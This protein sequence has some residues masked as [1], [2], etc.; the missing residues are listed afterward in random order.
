[1]PQPQVLFRCF[2][3]GSSGN[4]YYLGTQERGVLID[5]GISARGIQKNLREMGLDFQNIMGVLVTHDHADHIRA[6]GTL[7]ERV[8]L[9][10][11]TTKQIHD[12]ID[13]NWGVH[14]KLRTSRRYIEKGVPFQLFDMDI[15]TFGISHDSTD[16]LGYVI[17][18]FG[19]RFMIATDCGEPNHNMEAFIQTANHIVIE[20]N[21]DEQLLLNGPYPTYLK[22]RI[23]SPRGHQS[24]DTCGELLVRNY[25]D[26][27]RN[28]FLCH[29]SKENNDPQLALETIA[30]R[31]DNAG[32]VPG[33]DVFV[34][35]LDRLTPSPV[36]VLDDDIIN[37]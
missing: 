6:V 21:H 16:C 19:Q 23:L 15:T 29:L 34:R 11:Y 37:D 10:I 12:G 1:M 24:N 20:A 22:E 18:C 5:A 31:L 7:G 30:G 17:D 2:A 27:I 25:H 28:I 8:H 13:R 4:C 9:P 32:I 3:S 35:T 36:Y 14:E 26:G 33:R